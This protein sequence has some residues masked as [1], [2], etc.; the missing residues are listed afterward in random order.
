MRKPMFVVFGASDVEAAA[1]E[2]LLRDAGVAYGYAAVEGP[3]GRPVRVNPG[4]A[5][6]ATCWVFPGDPSGSHFGPAWDRVTHLF[7]CSPSPAVMDGLH[8]MEH[9]AAAWE[10]GGNPCSYCGECGGMSLAPVGPRWVV[11][12]HHRPGDPG[13]GRSP[14]EYWSASSLGQ[15]CK[16]LALENKVLPGP[17]VKG[18]WIPP[19]EL[20]FVAAADH[21]LEAAYRG[22]CPGVDPDA[23]MAWRA[24]SR[25]VFQKRP[26][27]DV[28]ADVGRARELL[29]ARVG[30]AGFADLRGESVPELPEAAAREGI[31]FLGTVRERDGREKVVLQA[32]PPALVARFLAG[33]LVPGLTGYYGDP[34]RGFAGGYA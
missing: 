24:E 7:E 12:D 21:C 8:E 9:E 3:D 15:L 23:L 17:W 31:P 28:L 19:K 33:E 26:V 25:A 22:A 4:N 27:E 14:A 29:R 34:A 30:A 2:G 6:K 16:E 1:A 18:E 11:L 32:A 10:R 20:M 13:Y 5:Y